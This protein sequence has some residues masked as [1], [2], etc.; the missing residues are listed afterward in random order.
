MI[1]KQEECARLNSKSQILSDKARMILK[2][3]WFSDLERLETI[4]QASK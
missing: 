4:Q 1:E 2:K 3:R